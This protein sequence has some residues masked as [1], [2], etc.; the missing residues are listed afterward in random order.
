MVAGTSKGPD[1]NQILQQ[2]F[3]STW[4]VH[5]HVYVNVDV[6]RARGRGRLFQI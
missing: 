3:T 6:S 2:P 4:H 1:R 5:D